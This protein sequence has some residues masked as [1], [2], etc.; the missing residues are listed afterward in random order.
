MADR[1]ADSALGLTAPGYVG[2]ER[3]LADLTS[4]LAD[5]ST[6]A[7][8]EGEA[9]IGKTRLVRECLSAPSL[10]AARILEA[11][12]P[13][14]H[15]PFPLGPIVDSLHRLWLRDGPFET[16]PLGGALRALFPE[17]SA[18]LPPALDPLEDPKATRH[19]LFRAII[20]IVVA[21][22]VDVFVL[23]DAH[24]ADSA[25][26]ELLLMIA[27]SSVRPF[28]LVVTF[29][30]ADVPAGSPLRLLAARS[31]ATGP[32]LRIALEA[33]NV[34]ETTRFLAAMVGTEDISAEFA[35][36]L[37][38]RTDGVPLALEEGVSLLHER[39]DIVRRDGE[40]TR[41][42]LSEL[43]VPPTVRDSILERVERLDRS[44]R[45][46]LEAAATLAE[47]ADEH[48]L[49]R[50]AG[51]DDDAIHRAL[52]AALKS[53]LL[54]EAEPATFL[55]R[56]VLASRAVEEAVPAPERRRLHRRAAEALLG[57]EPLPV[58][59]LSRH[60]RQ[61]GDIAGWSRHAEAA[62][63]L[64]LESGD[65]HAALVL[66]HDLMTAAQHPPERRI[67]LARKLGEAAAWGVAAL[68]ELGVEVTETLRGVL[69]QEDVPTRELAEIR[70]LTGRLLLQLGEFEAAS[71]EIEEA[72]AHLEARPDLSV[73]AMISLA[74]PRGPDWP[75]SKHLSWLERATQLRPRLDAAL[76]RTWLAV[77][78]ASALLMLGEED[79][80]PAAEEITSGLD[81]PGAS[82]S[83]Q[84]Q[85]ARGLM[86]VGH[87]A[88]AWGHYAESRERLDAAIELM[89]STA[90]ERLLNSA[91][92]T[93]SLLEWQ[94]GRWEGLAERIADLAGAEDT[95]PEAQLEARLLLG[96]LDLASGNKD[97]SGQRL[98][99]ALAEAGRRGLIDVQVSPA[100]ALGRLS[101]SDGDVDRALAVTGPAVE[102]IAGKGM[103]LWATE[104]VPAHVDALVAAERTDVAEILVRRF[105]TGL[106]DRAA[107][108]PEAALQ[109]CLGVMA[110]VA[111]EPERAARILADAAAA[112]AE[113]PCPYQELLTIERYSRQLL[114][115][116]HEAQ[117][118]NSL[119]TA[120]QRLQALGARWDADRVA[121][122]LRQHG[123]EVS[124]T[125]RGGRRGYGD[126]LSPR[127]LEVVRLVARGMTNRQAAESLF[128]SPRTVDR[129]LS[130]AMRKLD[131][132]SRTALAMAAND[133]GLLADDLE[134]FG[135]RDGR[136]S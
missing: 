62:A 89:R 129:H 24:W 128:L 96:L 39:G 59:R 106:G 93:L 81:K 21:A 88:I 76:D 102:L 43:Q 38:E 75:V 17:W 132:G 23:E 97:I 28:S 72:V 74:F 16:S 54:R 107:P 112:W 46:V 34:D 50:V 134:A 6:I 130:A 70:L 15:E 124:R 2:R 123:V 95:L 3:E 71:A 84:R 9:G 11:V 20:E 115:A 120:Q 4:A 22:G 33:L 26:L 133:G 82:L 5:P 91:R 104:V 121:H 80:W 87:L 116:G 51:L 55:C 114:A 64:A 14:L 32:P 125:W 122:L 65:D 100:A 13:P 52:T 78:R 63:D 61:A 49:A 48:I 110:G 58:A 37:H 111:G 25:T 68:G 44:A 127:E 18:D 118:M 66:L 79:G 36:F 108:A 101:L 119:T 31:A 41:R 1:R 98:E 57:Q 29:R 12:C 8:V 40:W 117:A 69:R 77:D 126:Q 30:P 113:L 99:A 47:P 103:W 94:E 67:R 90:Y 56:H 7:L 53:G 10:Q 73:R 35:A 83:E 86:N 19:R 136:A 60:F 85:V 109:V 135:P 45:S 131:V 42:S 105:A 27:A 92:L